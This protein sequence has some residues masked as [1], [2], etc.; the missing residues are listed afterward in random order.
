MKLDLRKLTSM[1][2]NDYISS[3][4]EPLTD[5]QIKK[6][7][8]LVYKITTNNNKK[9][10]RKYMGVMV[11]EQ[12]PSSFIENYNNM[13]DELEQRQDYIDLLK[14]EVTKLKE[15]LPYKH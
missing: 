10:E 3:Y 1:D 4:P 11:C 13:I 7:K 6:T 8:K 9:T 15:Q 12:M 2:I 5:E 14:F